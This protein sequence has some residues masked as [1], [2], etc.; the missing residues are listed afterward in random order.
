MSLHGRVYAR[1]HWDKGLAGT[2]IETE[3]SEHG[4]TTLR[5]TVPDS[6]AKA[7]ALQLANDTVGVTQVVDA[8]TIGP[9]SATSTTTTTT[10]TETQVEKKR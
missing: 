9:A 2:N 3:V 8:L 4:L 1:L 6:K 10:T 7:K 5:G